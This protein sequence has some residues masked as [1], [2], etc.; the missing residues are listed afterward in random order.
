MRAEFNRTL[1]F[2]LLVVLAALIYLDHNYKE[3]TGIA[4]QGFPRNAETINGSLSAR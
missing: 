3:D 4:Q 2:V 1:T